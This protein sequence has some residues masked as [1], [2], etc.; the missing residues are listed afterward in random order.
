MLSIQVPSLQG[1]ETLLFK[2]R[3]GSGIRQSWQGVFEGDHWH[4]QLFGSK[5]LQIK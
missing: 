2:Y 3:F 5:R 4:V 1:T